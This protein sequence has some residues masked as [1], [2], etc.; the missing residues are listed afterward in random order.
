[1]DHPPTEGSVSSEM[2]L[3]VSPP[4][5]C[6]GRIYILALCSL[7]FLFSPCRAIADFSGLV[8]SFLDGDTIKVLHNQRPERIGLSGI[9][10]PEK[11]QAYGKRAKQAASESGESYDTPLAPLNGTPASPLAVTNRKSNL[12]PVHV[13]FNRYGRLGFGFFIS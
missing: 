8:V 7:L 4:F 2:P 12:G 5:V 13:A 1:M 11:G 10:C 6:R 9:D 3:F